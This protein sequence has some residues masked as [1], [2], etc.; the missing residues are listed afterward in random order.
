MADIEPAPGLFGKLR[1]EID[2][3]EEEIAVVFGRHEKR[4]ANLEAQIPPNPPETP[5]PITSASTPQE[6]ATAQ[7]I[8]TEPPVVAVAA[9]AIPGSVPE[10]A[11]P[12]APNNIA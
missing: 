10:A 8:P 4:V 3:L 1:A 5:A 6:V 9:P 12:P 2:R 11:T 7:A